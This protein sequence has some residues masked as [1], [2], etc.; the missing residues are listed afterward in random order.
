MLGGISSLF[1]VLFSSHS[2]RLTSS[3]STPSSAFSSWRVFSLF[4]WADS[5]A[6]LQRKMYCFDLVSLPVIPLLKSSSHLQLT[7]QPSALGSLRCPCQAVWKYLYLS[8][9][10][11][12]YLFSFLE[13]PCPFQMEHLKNSSSATPACFSLY[14][15]AAKGTKW[16]IHI[17]FTYRFIQF[18]PLKINI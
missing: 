16:D 5:S 3:S 15:M 17:K 6:E 1:S 12:S 8:D 7:L 10:Y 18:I 14:L 9:M 13:Q 11:F 2:V 4:L